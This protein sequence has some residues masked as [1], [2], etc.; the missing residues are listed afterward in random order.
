MGVKTLEH[1][2]HIDKAKIGIYWVL[3]SITYICYFLIFFGLYAVKPEF[4]QVVSLVFHSLICL[5]LLWRFHPFRTEYKLHPYDGNIIFGCALIL[6]INTTA[7]EGTTFL[8]NPTTYFIK[9]LSIT[10][11]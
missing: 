2:D 4:I 9:L 6:L 7:A 3:M 1:L 8:K 10:P 5:F 11:V